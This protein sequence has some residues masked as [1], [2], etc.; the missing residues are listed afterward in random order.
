[1]LQDRV[2]ALHSLSE[3][4]N[5]TMQVDILPS[6]PTVSYLADIAM[7]NFL[8]E[9]MAALQGLMIMAGV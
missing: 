3:V 4:T 2:A 9:I 1:M 8:Y 6:G 5:C 7:Q